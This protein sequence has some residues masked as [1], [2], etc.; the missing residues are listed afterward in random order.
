MSAGPGRPLPSPRGPEA[1]ARVGTGPPA[2]T[3]RGPLRRG[4]LR[5]H[6]SPALRGRG[7]GGLRAR[8]PL[9]SASR[10]TA[11]AF[12]FSGARF[13]SPVPRSPSRCS[14]IRPP[15]FLSQSA[16]H[17][18][19]RFG[20]PFP[21]L[22]FPVLHPGARFPVLPPPP[23]PAPSG[24]GPELRGRSGRSAQRLAP[25]AAPGAAPPDR[26]PPSGGRPRCERAPSP[27][28]PPGALTQLFLPPLPAAGPHRSAPRRPRGEGGLGGAGWGGGTP[29]PSP[30]G[31]GGTARGGDGQPSSPIGGGRCGALPNGRGGGGRFLEAAEGG[32]GRGGG[33]GGGGGGAAAPGPALGGA[34][35]A[36]ERG[37]R[38]WRAA[39]ARSGRGERGARR[40]DGSVCTEGATDAP[41]P[42][43]C[44]QPGPGE[45]R[46]SGAPRRGRCR[47]VRSVP[48]LAHGA[49]RP[50]RARFP[51]RFP[52][53]FSIT[54]LDGSVRSAYRER[55]GRELPADAD[56][57]AGAVPGRGGWGLRAPLGTRRAIPGL[58]RR[59]RWI[60]GHRDASPPLALT[61]PALPVRRSGAPGPRVAP[62]RGSVAAEPLGKHRQRGCR[63]LSAPNPPP[64]RSVPIGVPASSC[65][66]A[67]GLPRT[68]PAPLSSRLGMTPDGTTG[69]ALM[70]HPIPGS[71]CGGA[72][73]ARP[74]HT[75][76]FGHPELCGLC[77]AP[78]SVL[79]SPRAA[80][81]AAV[82]PGRGAVF[83][84]TP[85][86][87]CCLGLWLPLTG[88]LLP[89]GVRGCGAA[90]FGYPG[91]LLASSSGC[92]LWVRCLRV[93]SRR[94]S[95][96]HS[97]ARPVALWAQLPHGGWGSYGLGSPPVPAEGTRWW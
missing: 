43:R 72:H 50:F 74:P 35:R 31:R 94:A 9:L 12:P 25:G 29:P 51:V 37:A 58:R 70:V 66:S 83:T 6:R 80:A 44:P 52:V 24:A 27:P 81:P 46:R 63:A 85:N 76:P 59:R 1:A 10:C 69:A 93:E 68:C 8:C 47:S 90:L 34:G 86:N 38:R 39:E 7:R 23:Q 60:T 4:E 67:W 73:G 2:G 62:S 11:P 13:F 77:P 19:L 20:A 3:C 57:S 41:L 14:V 36:G 95:V 18:V 22:R 75:P 54:V 17:S 96:S 71:L 26:A 5:P 78:S 53:R 40:T 30:E 49:V 89:F 15:L 33:A 87:G 64:L 16:A 56:T 92:R 61:V 88:G 42:A 65:P 32:A 97:R 45:S 48:G 84:L 55:R 91:P 28:P 79:C 21:T 82:C